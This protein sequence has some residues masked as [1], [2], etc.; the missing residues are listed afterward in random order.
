MS[1]HGITA[2]PD[3]RSRNSGNKFRLA[4][5]PK[6]AKFRHAPT[7]SVQDIRCG[8][9]LHPE[10]VGQ[11]SQQV[12]RSVIN[13]QAVHEFLQQLCLQTAQFQRY[14]HTDRQTGLLQQYHATHYSAWRGKNRDAQKK[15]SRHGHLT[16]AS[17]YSQHLPLHL[18]YPQVPTNKHSVISKTGSF[19]IL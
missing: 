18:Y 1:P 12:S 19:N 3:Q 5:S 7:K 11:S 8:K 17:S 6:L 2:A 15:R 10:K 14:R 16:L 13:R 9:I 4:R